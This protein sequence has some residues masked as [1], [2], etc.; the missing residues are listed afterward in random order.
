MHCSVSSEH[1]EFRY[2]GLFEKLPMKYL[3]HAKLN[4]IEQHW[5][6]KSTGGSLDSLKG[7][8]SNL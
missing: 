8:S 5:T 6:S 2:F 1:A 3:A 4:L 7:S